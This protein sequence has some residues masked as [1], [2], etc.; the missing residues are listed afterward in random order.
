L[1]VVGG[2]AAGVYASIRAKT[3]APHLNVVVV[4]KGKF[5]SKVRLAHQCSVLIPM[6][7]KHMYY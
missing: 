2:G 4:E 6:D 5:L 7:L 1:V 3:L